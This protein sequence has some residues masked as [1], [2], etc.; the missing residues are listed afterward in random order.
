MLEPEIALFGVGPGMQVP[1]S[2]H[3][4]ELYGDK[5]NRLLSEAHSQAMLVGKYQKTLLE[6]R[7]NAKK[8]KR[9]QVHTINRLVGLQYRWGGFAAAAQYRMIM[10]ELDALTN[11][12]SVPVQEN[13]ATFTNDDFFTKGV[14]TYNMVH[15]PVVQTH[16]QFLAFKA[17]IEAHLMMIKRQARVVDQDEFLFSVISNDTVKGGRSSNWASVLPYNNGPGKMDK[18]DVQKL[19][20]SR[21][22]PHSGLTF[23]QLAQKIVTIQLMAY[24][25]IVNHKFQTGA[26]RHLTPAEKESYLTLRFTPHTTTWPLAPGFHGFPE[27][28]EPRQRVEVKTDSVQR[29]DLSDAGKL[30]GTDI[31]GSGTQTAV[32]TS[33]VHISTSEG[34]CDVMCLGKLSEVREKGDA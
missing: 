29:S 30:G 33:V 24:R 17:Q 7:S 18:G 14:P 15:L 32:P 4:T 8:I 22:E 20:S 26:F 1:A 12:K 25:M 6:L 31:L 16:Y 13:Y 11:L 21:M 5:L 2:M 19:V 23:Q 34:E 27:Q 28:A 10:N 3:T 9:R